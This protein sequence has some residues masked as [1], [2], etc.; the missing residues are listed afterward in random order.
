MKSQQNSPKAS[1]K[2]KTQRPTEYQKNTEY[3]A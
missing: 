2:G 1:E 3:T